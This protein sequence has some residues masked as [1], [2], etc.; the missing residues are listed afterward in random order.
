VPPPCLGHFGHRLYESVH[1]ADEERG[2]APQHVPE[3]EVGVAAFRREDN[4]DGEHRTGDILH[5]ERLLAQ[6]VDEAVAAVAA[7]GGDTVAAAAAAGGGDAAAAAAA[8]TLAHIVSICTFDVD[9]GKTVLRDPI[10][11]Y[12][13]HSWIR[14]PDSGFGM[15]KIRIRDIHL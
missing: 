9:K 3:E 7:G 15:E 4:A 6:D 12:F 10:S 8:V 1:E 13:F 11:S 5:E 14:N 2:E